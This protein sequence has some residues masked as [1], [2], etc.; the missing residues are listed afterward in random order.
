[1]L[2]LGKGVI[3]SL[4]LLSNAGFMQ[5]ASAEAHGLDGKGT[6]DLLALMAAVKAVVIIFSRCEKLKSAGPGGAEW[7]A[8]GAVNVSGWKS[9]WGDGARSEPGSGGR[10]AGTEMGSEGRGPE[11]T[12]A[13]VGGWVLMMGA[14]V[15]GRVLGPGTA[16]SLL[17][18][19]R[20]R[21]RW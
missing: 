5:E 19:S 11:G 1:M 12:L 3:F 16:G 18:C 13:G 21:R 9:C 4:P 14:G 7:G 6:E 20:A 8:G 10:G 2:G 15:G 17:D